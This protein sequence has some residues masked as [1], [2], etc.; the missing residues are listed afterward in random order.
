MGEWLSVATFFAGAFVG[1]AAGVVGVEVIGAGDT[2][3]AAAG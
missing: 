2:G 3:A 1:V